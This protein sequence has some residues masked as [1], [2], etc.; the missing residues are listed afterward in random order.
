M[1]KITAVG[2]RREIT[3]PLDQSTTIEV[4]VT[5]REIGQRGGP[6]ED[7]NETYDFLSSLAGHKVGLDLQRTRTVSMKEVD[8]KKFA[9][10]TEWPGFVNRKMH[11]RPQM[12]QQRGK[13]ARMID[14]KPTFFTTYLS[15]VE[16]P[17]IDLRDKN[18]VLVQTNPELF[19]NVN[20]RPASVR[21]LEEPA[22][23]TTAPTNTEAHVDLHQA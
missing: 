4:N 10:G 13:P 7:M 23:T 17:D 16:K 8:A 2:G 12:E 11:S 3:N 6:N 15:T 1:V 20:L 18:E 22:P 21:L 9:V 5:F 14:N 19:A